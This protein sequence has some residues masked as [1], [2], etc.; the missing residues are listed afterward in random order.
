MIIEGMASSRRNLF[1]TLAHVGLGYLCTVT[2]FVLI[3]W[4]YLILLTNFGKSITQIS[5][6]KP[7]FFL[8]LFS[9]MIS[10]EVLDRM[11]KTS[12]FI[13]YELGKYML[14]FVGIV[15]VIYIGV[16]S[17]TGLWMAF[18]VTPALFYDFSGGRVQYDFINYY[19]GP[20]A[21]GLGVAFADRLPI[22]SIALDQ[23]LKLIFWGC[24]SSL[25]FTYI[26]TPDFEEIEFTLR[27]QSETTGGHS[28]NQVSTIMGLGMFLSFYTLI[29][30]LNFSG[31]R[32]LD[33][34]VLGGFTFQ[35]LLS[36]SRG[37][38][39][40]G[41]LGIMILLFLP[42]ANSL[43][44]IPNKRINS[45]RRL[46]FSLIALMSIYGTFEIANE[47][48]GGNLLLRYR[49]ETQG[50]LLGKEKTAN[51]I[52]SG[53]LDIL[54]KDLD[55]FI[56]Y[57][58][59]GVGCGISQYLRDE[60]NGKVAAHIELSRLFADHGLLGA[61]NASLLFIAL[62]LRVWRKNHNSPSRNILFVLLL[63]ALATTF[64]AAMRTFLTPLLIILSVVRIENK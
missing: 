7:V 57:P 24:L 35:G 56:K 6:R 14:V 40:V 29:K 47:I 23:I 37:G 36:F 59:T 33:G 2:P 63:I 46:L 13:P 58:L 4:F 45:N 53:R 8:M 15:G 38:M 3:G 21:V 44:R 5:N 41:V 26:K 16:R 20:L 9:Y 39:M 25:V 54:E 52:T 48:T 22:S 50:T 43:G 17:K 1:W 32:I 30:R 19:L 34:I 49:G 51:Q 10:F 64:H 18:L 61:I 31:N 42:E 62:P 55:L 60:K 11:A 12:P 27:A 28:S